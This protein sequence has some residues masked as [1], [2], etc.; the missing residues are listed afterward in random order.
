[1]HA[2]NALAVS[3]FPAFLSVASIVAAMPSQL[4]PLWQFPSGGQQFCVGRG[5]I[6]QQIKNPQAIPFGELNVFRLLG[7]NL[8]R[9]HFRVL[10][11]DTPN[12]PLKEQRVVA[13]RHRQRQ[14]L[15]ER[16]LSAAE[17]HGNPAGCDGNPLREI[18]QLLVD[19]GDG[20]FHQDCGTAFAL[21]RFNLSGQPASALVF[22]MSGLTGGQSLQVGD[23]SFAIRH[24]TDSDPALDAGS[25]NLLRATRSDAQQILDH[26]SVDP[27][28]RQFPQPA[29][30]FV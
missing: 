15:L 21:E 18:I 7:S 2:Y 6:L 23:H 8:V 9:S 27:G 25:N 16:I 12:H 29:G 24:A 10:H 17:T 14:E 19:D 1:V 4:Y 11:L 13:D 20:R 5:R 28:V 3:N 26:A 30:D 22:V